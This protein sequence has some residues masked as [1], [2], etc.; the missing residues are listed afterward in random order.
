MIIAHG[1]AGYLLTKL[2]TNTIFRNSISPQHNAKRYNVLILTGIIGG[3]MPDFDFICYILSSSNRIPHHLYLTHMPFFWICMMSLL[4]VTGTLLRK[5]Y[6]TAVSITLCS[7][8]LLHL[9]FDT[10]TGDIYWLYPFSRHPFNVFSVHGTYI[11]W[12]HNYM[13]HWTFLFEI[14]IITYAMI[15]FLRI[16]ETFRHLF[17]IV[18]TDKTLQ[19]II[20]RLSICAVGITL[21]LLVGSIKFE[22]DDKVIKK[23]MSLKHHVSKNLSVVK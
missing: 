11:W 9:I 20:V 1:P 18:Q 10:L 7:S 15:L 17:F 13:H 8:A 6:F 12:V 21:I 19:K 22:F 5:P 23:V 16:Q 2:F 14:A 4:V 3:I